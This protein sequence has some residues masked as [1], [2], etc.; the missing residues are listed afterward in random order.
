MAKRAKGKDVDYTIPGLLALVGIVVFTAL[1][2][3]QDG[4]LAYLASTDENVAGQAFADNTYDADAPAD[5]AV[6]SWCDGSKL[7]RQREDCNQ[8]VAFC[9]Y[10]CAVYDGEAVC[11]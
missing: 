4:K 6:Q 10:G 11:N 1:F 7:V 5:C 3:A 9:Q 2:F 8:Y